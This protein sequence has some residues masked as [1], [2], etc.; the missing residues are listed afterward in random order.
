MSILWILIPGLIV[1][2]LLMDSVRRIFS[3][4]D[5]FVRGLF[6]SQPVTMIAAATIVGSVI[7]WAVLEAL[8][9]W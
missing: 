4:D 5:H 9:L 3:D 8:S 7:V 2:V 1:G 6:E